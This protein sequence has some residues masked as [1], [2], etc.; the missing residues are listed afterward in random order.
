MEFH[1]ASLVPT[2]L[3]HR[4]SK[5]VKSPPVTTGE[6]NNIADAMSATTSSKIWKAVCSG[7]EKHSGESNKKTQLQ[8][9]LQPLSSIF[10]FHEIQLPLIHY[11]E[12]PDKTMSSHWLIK[13]RNTRQ[14]HINMGLQQGDAYR[15]TWKSSG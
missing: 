2:Q 7:L 6:H 8:K 1:G 5:D 15:E 13:E 9:R 10:D 3:E 4:M 12:Q 14:P 11:E